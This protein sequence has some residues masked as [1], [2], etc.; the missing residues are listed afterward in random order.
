MLK[1]CLIASRA[2]TPDNFALIRLKQFA[3]YIYCTITSCWV[4]C[5]VSIHYHLHV[6]FTASR[7]LFNLLSSACPQQMLH[8]KWRAVWPKTLFHA[9][10]QNDSFCRWEIME[11]IC[12]ILPVYHRAIVFISLHPFPI[13]SLLMPIHRPLTLFCR[14]KSMFCGYALVDN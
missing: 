9:F 2:M 1:S 6:I 8:F 3:P 5:D 10:S 14:T 12:L 7:R 13:T 11:R 4:Y